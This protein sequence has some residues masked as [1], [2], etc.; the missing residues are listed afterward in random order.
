MEIGITGNPKSIGISLSGLFQEVVMQINLFNISSNKFY[1]KDKAM[2]N[3][4]VRDSPMK[5]ID[6]DKNLKRKICCTLNDR[7]HTDYNNLQSRGI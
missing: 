7:T 6:D 4:W 3:H 5:P 1:I 2:M